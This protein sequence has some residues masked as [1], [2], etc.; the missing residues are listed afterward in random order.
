MHRTQTIE[1][2]TAAVDKNVATVCLVCGGKKLH[3]NFS[4]GKFRVEECADCGLM[5]LNPQPTDQDLASFYRPNYF[6]FADD[7]DSQRHAGELESS[8]ADHYLDLLESYAGAPLTGRLLE[9]GC[10]HGDFLTRAA[11]RG[12]A[13]TGVEYSAC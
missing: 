7:T 5:R 10:G 2:V 12:L 4:I 1:D 8:T 11:A 3:Y 9:V 6:V 13:V